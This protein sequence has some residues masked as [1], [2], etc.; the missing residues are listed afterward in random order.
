MSI[1]D[2]YIS[3]SDASKMLQV[4]VQYVRELIRDGLIKGEKIGTQWIIEKASLIDYITGN[5]IT[6]N[7]AD[8]IRKTNDIP[9][10][11]GLSFF[12]GAMGL[13]IGLENVKRP[14]ICLAFFLAY[15]IKAWCPKW[16]PSKYPRQSERASNL[17]V[18]F[19]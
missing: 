6:I 17:S 9:E 10:I 13:D 4:S 15:L 3:A 16:T 12:S 5:N 8:Q 14:R 18:G 2:K 11:V 19:L 1:N 7:P